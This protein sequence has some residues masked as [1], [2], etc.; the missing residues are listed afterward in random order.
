MER[1][2]DWES[3]TLADV[4]NNNWQ[5]NATVRDHARRVYRA[6]DKPKCCCYCGYSTHYE[7]AHVK[8]I[9]SFPLDTTLGVVNHLDNLVALCR[10]HHWEFD[11]GLVTLAPLT[12]VEPA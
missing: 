12:G 2:L 9:A 5:R 6:S 8:D 7:V 4:A 10:N 3:R 11:H 1:S